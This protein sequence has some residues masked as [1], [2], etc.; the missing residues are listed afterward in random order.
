LSAFGK[1]IAPFVEKHGY[2]VPFAGDPDMAAYSQ[3]ASRYIPRNFV[4]GPDGTVLYQSQ[5][6]ERHEFEE[7]VTLIES[8]NAPFAQPCP[9]PARTPI[10]SL[11][12]SCS[13]ATLLAQANAQKTQTR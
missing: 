6:Y 4:I 10:L 2:T 1:R 8:A 13:D 12:E 5:G 3:Y 9:D 11:S 7:M